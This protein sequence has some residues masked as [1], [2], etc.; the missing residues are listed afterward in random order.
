GDRPQGER[1]F[2]D[3]PQFGDRDGRGDRPTGE[4]RFGDRDARGGFRPESR[5]RDDRPRDDRP[6][7]DRPRDDRRG[8]GGRPAARTH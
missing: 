4:R 1:R 7:E 6:R 2:G 8:F 3:R 5:V